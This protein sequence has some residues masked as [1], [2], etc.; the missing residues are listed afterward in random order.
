MSQ[1]RHTMRALLAC[2]LGA[3]RAEGGRRVLPGAALRAGQLARDPNRYMYTG[4]ADILSIRICFCSTD[5]T[6]LSVVQWSEE[7]G[8]FMLREQDQRSTAAHQPRCQLQA[9][10]LSCPKGGG[11]VGRLSR[12]QKI[13]MRSMSTDAIGGLTEP[14]SFIRTPLSTRERMRRAPLGASHPTRYKTALV[15]RPRRGCDRD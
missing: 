7:R 2:L 4:P 10:R 9:A 6:F 15:R 5:E 13:T 3:Q 11:N 8:S 1:R 14:R 12:R